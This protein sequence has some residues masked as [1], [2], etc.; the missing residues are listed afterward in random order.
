MGVE[1][2]YSF[3]DLYEA[4]F[5]KKVDAEYREEFFS[6]SQNKRNRE[7]E[8][9]AEISNWQVEKRIGTDGLTYF[10]FA[11]SFRDGS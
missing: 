8:K 1:C 10:A 11:P 3:W 5:G 2:R 4:A 6:M 7:V 9:W